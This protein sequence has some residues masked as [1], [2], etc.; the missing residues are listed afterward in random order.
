MANLIRLRKA[1]RGSRESVGWE[2]WEILIKGNYPEIILYYSLLPL[3]SCLLP[4]PKRFCS[5]LKYKC[6][7]LL[8]T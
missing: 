2:V 5:Q 1:H 7:R 4:L 6:Y 3:A 8:F